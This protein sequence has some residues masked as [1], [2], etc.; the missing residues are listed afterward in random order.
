MTYLSWTDFKYLI[1]NQKI[2][3]Q[4]VELPSQYILATSKNFYTLQCE[5]PKNGKADQVDFETNYKANVNQE[6]TDNSNRLL[7]RP[8][9]AKKGW[10]YLAHPIEVETSKLNSLYSKD[11]DNTD[12][13][14]ITLKFY[15]SNDVELIAGTQTELDNNCVKTVLHFSPNY[16]Y[17]LI[18]GKIYHSIK[19]TTDI[20]VWVQGGIF[21]LGPN[22]IKTM[23][24]GIN[25]K[26][27]N[28]SNHVN[29]D[30]RA[31]KYMQKDITGLPYQGNQMKFIIKH[32]AGINHKIMVTLEY[33]RA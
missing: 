31:S 27:I 20:R 8:V 33:Y 15:D 24:G 22:Y 7:V 32:N 18:G 10:V 28:E 5:I 16:D 17:E 13:N 21:E 12:F 2:Y 3:V 25:L 30:G 23:I 1:D 19:P 14:G 11:A 29:I 6:I 26:N 9:A 4:M